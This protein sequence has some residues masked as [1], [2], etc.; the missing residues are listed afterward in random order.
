[1]TLQG[2]K[3]ASPECGT[4]YKPTNPVSEQINGGREI[5]RGGWALLVDKRGLGDLTPNVICEPSL[6]QENQL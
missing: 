6:A 5:G 3:E 2:S 1:M 4:F